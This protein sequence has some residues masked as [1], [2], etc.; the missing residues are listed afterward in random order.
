MKVVVV[1]MMMMMMMM[2]SKTEAKKVTG[3]NWK[4]Y[5]APRFPSWDV[6]FEGAWPFRVF[7]RERARSLGCRE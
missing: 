5:S 6:L 2:M 3:L 4:N 1:V 7:E